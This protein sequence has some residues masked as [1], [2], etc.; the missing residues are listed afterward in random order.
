[1]TEAALLRLPRAATADLRPLRSV[2]EAMDGVRLGACAAALVPIENSI[3]GSV[4]VTLDTLVRDTPP[5]IAAEVVLPVSFVLAGRTPV[6]TIA[7][8]PHAL[9]QCRRYL[10]DH[11]P[12]AATIDALST[13]G[14]A[15][16]VARGGADACVCAR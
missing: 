6:A 9:A 10:R 3:E 5:G 12:E 2:P 1:F 13:A 8:H 11:H 16:L 14:A 7:S 15:D 4:P